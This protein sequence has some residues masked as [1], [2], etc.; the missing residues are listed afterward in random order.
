MHVIENTTMH[1]PIVAFFESL[2]YNDA[3]GGVFRL[4]EASSLAT[5]AT[6]VHRAA[7]SGTTVDNW[8]AS[9]AAMG[10]F[11]GVMKVGSLPRNIPQQAGQRSMPTTDFSVNEMARPKPMP[12]PPGRPLTLSN[13]RVA[14]VQTS[15][16]RIVQG[17]L[18]SPTTPHMINV[19][20]K[21]ILTNPTVITS[22][23]RNKILW[24]QLNKKNSFIGG[25]S[26]GINNT[27]IDYAVEVIQV[28]PNGTRRVN[29][30]VQLPD[31]RLKFKKNS[32]L[33]PE[34]W[35]DSRVSHSIEMVGNSRPIKIRSHDDA[36]WHRGVIDGVE[37]DVIKIGNQVISAYPTGTINAKPPGGFE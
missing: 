16:R 31:G 27:H 35:S 14:N 32:T 5:H 8:F 36:T 37:I 19:N 33:F 25:H 22:E 28:N 4:S 2:G 13:G 18:Q 34:N 17:N 9:L 26:S 29:F 1:A 20:G 30:Y 7:E 15:A 6:F 10:V 12:K 11:E 23:M 3:D 21:W 24:G